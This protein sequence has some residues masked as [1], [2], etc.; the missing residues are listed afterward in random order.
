MVCR[1]TSTDYL[2]ALGYNVV[3][4][5][6]SGIV[7]LGVVGCMGKAVNYLGHVQYLLSNPPYSFPAINSVPAADVNGKTSDLLNLGIGL[8]IS[9]KHHWCNGWKPWG[10]NNIHRCREDSVK[11]C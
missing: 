2:K 8:N 5:P 9:W 3:R 7:P 1:D 6:R 4:L 11:I 10:Y